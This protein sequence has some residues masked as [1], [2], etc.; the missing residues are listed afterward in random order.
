MDCLNVLYQHDN[1]YAVF[2]GV[3]ILSL[4]ENNR[5][6]P[7]ICVY[8]IDMGLDDSYKQQYCALAQ[9]YGRRIQFLPGQQIAH[10]IENLGL[11]KYRGS[12]ATYMKLF[13]VEMLP[14][15]VGRIYYLDSDL[16]VEGNLMPLMSIDMQGNALA[17]V[18]DGLSLAFKDIYG[19]TKEEP[20]FCGGTILFDIHSWKEQ[21]CL[22][23]LCK[24]AENVRGA[25]FAA[26]QDLLNLA[27]K[28]RITS[29]DVRYDFTY[30]H[31][32]YPDYMFLKK[33]HDQAYYTQE[34]L[35]SARENIVVLH[36][37]RFLGQS[38]WNS[39]SLHPHCGRFDLYLSL[40]PWKDYKKKPARNDLVFRIER[41]LY[42]Y[43]PRSVFFWL[44]MTYYRHYVVAADRKLKES[45]QRD[46][47]F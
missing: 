2:G 26:D 16:L 9:Q 13:A 19:L 45:I 29:L 36:F 44:F 38:P 7:D 43:M 22:Q 3:S 46:I 15:T 33:F 20:Y 1:N 42:R 28:G 40:S 37:M 24:Y 31:T 6:A 23:T 17:M 10:R 21:K 18:R 14:E 11:P 35:Q 4:F 25:F 5:L 30:I 32:I 41:W 34:Q 8:M 47:T 12:Y 27:L 39:E